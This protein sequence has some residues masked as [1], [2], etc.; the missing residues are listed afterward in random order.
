MLVCFALLPAFLPC[1][2]PFLF[3]SSFRSVSKPSQNRWCSCKPFPGF[4]VLLTLLN[5]FWRLQG[6]PAAVRSKTH[7]DRDFLRFWPVLRFGPVQRQIGT[8]RCRYESSH[9][10]RY[11]RIYADTHSHRYRQIIYIYICSYTYI[12]TYI[13]LDRYIF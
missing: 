8:E 13:H 4:P 11:T 5:K 9:T 3:S 1:S 12:Y 6:W 10:L 2:L 7:A